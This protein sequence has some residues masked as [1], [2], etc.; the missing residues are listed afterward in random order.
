VTVRAGKLTSTPRA[1]QDVTY[2][3]KKYV[4]GHVRERYW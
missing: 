3:P 4:H 2:E 1:V